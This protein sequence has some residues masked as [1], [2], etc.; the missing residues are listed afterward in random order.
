MRGQK[1]KGK[2]GIGRQSTVYTRAGQRRLS[3]SSLFQP[4]KIRTAKKSSTKAMESVIKEERIVISSRSCMDNH[5][6]LQCRRFLRSIYKALT[7]LKHHSQ[8][9][10]SQLWPP[11]TLYTALIKEKHLVQSQQQQQ[12]KNQNNNKKALG[13]AKNKKPFR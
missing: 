7:I 13:I 2:T 10:N 11:G 5:C 12:Q 3:D 1:K 8:L 6:E 4:L 9:S